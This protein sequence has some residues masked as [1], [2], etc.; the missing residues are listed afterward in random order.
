MK[1]LFSNSALSRKFVLFFCLWAGT[2]QISAQVVFEEHPQ[3]AGECDGR[4]TRF[5]VTVSN[6][7]PVYRW[8]EFNGRDWVDIPGE[9][10]QGYSYTTN[11]AG[12]YRC[13]VTVPPFVAYSNPA[14]LTVHN[15]PKIIEGIKAPAVCHG[16]V[17]RA[18]TVN[19]IDDGGKPEDMKYIW[20]LN[21]IDVGSGTMN[22]NHVPDL[23][24]TA[25]DSENGL[26]L[27]LTVSNEC[28]TSDPAQ[29]VIDVK[30]TPLLPTPVVR[31]YCF[32]DESTP[33]AISEEYDNP[34]ENPYLKIEAVWYETDVP[35]EQGSS[36]APSPDT[37]VA[38]FLYERWVSQKIHYLDEGVACESNR[39]KATVKILE[40]S[41]PPDNLPTEAKVLC[42]G[43]PSPTFPVG[44]TDLRWYDGQKEQLL[45]APQINTSSTA[46]QTFYVTQKE[47]GKCESPFEQGKINVVVQ[48]RS[49]VDDIIISSYIPNTENPLCPN[50]DISITVTAVQVQNT[51]F[52]WYANQNKTGLIQEDKTTSANPFSTYKTPKLWNE[53]I[54]YIS[55]QE[56]GNC[57]SSYPKALAINV[58]DNELP[59]I[60]APKNIEVNTDP[61][62]CYASAV[63]VGWPLRLSDNCTDSSN[64]VIYINYDKV[65]FGSD[66]LTK[67][68]EIDDLRHGLDTTLIWWAED[69]AGRMDY[70]LQ[71]I[72]IRDREKPQG[73]C[74]LNVTRIID[75]SETS[76]V[77]DYESELMNYTDNC[78]DVSYERVNGDP[79]G[80]V[81]SLGEH[82]IRHHISD[83][84]GNVDT[85]EFYV[86][87][88]HPHRDMELTLR[89]SPNNQIC[90][91]QEV[92]LA[93]EISGGSGRVTYSWKPRPWTE[94]VMKDYP[95]V[96]VTE[97]E[98]TVSDGITTQTKSAKITVLQTRQVELTL[99]GR[100]M[101]EI[102]EGDEVLVTATSGYDTYK[103]MLNGETIQEAGDSYQV[104]FQAELGTYIARVFATDE[105]YCVTQ[106]Q[107]I[108]QIDSRKLPNVFTPNFDGDNDIFLEHLETPHAPENF[109]LE[110]FTR[111]GVLLYKGNKGWNGFYK[112][113]VMPQGTYIYVVKRRMNSGEY[114]TF[115]GNVTLKI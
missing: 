4:Y 31:D 14:T 102:F 28:G 95:P 2:W 113:K 63:N 56:E 46:P 93:S 24:R 34:A 7:M 101:E 82:L 112:G 20:R 98:L 71:N 109:Q 38:P 58:K 91:G 15:R 76:V 23:I 78:S 105:N 9:E 49:K 5:F 43:D 64:L 81:F 48:D 73:K 40:L 65:E 114:R 13:E 12:T 42:L 99:V 35:T 111:T 51:I 72:S 107:M 106:D 29:K 90:P 25:N 50:N 75:V 44:G 62:K 60:T 79:S 36:K 59:K 83:A 66:A 54:Y 108:I 22:N 84:A 45:T 10:A 74:P 19:A 103:L 88:K 110:I 97:Y 26:L 18:Y 70:A 77:V 39:A 85:C 53:S 67:F 69:D 61:G 6:D 104:S 115:K 37:K 21:G 27:T 47:A 68:F 86:I 89:I 1:T 33:L 41:Y 57:E 11:I 30:P 17:L 32:K 3:S 8:Q 52:R 87:V 55:I 80:S 96:G 100:P 92:V 16:E 94:P